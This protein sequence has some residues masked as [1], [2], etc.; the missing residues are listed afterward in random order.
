M[1]CFPFV[2]EKF[3]VGR[4]LKMKNPYQNYRFTFYLP[5][6]SIGLSLAIIR[7]GSQFFQIR[8]SCSY[9]FCG[10]GISCSRRKRDSNPFSTILLHISG[11]QTAPRLSDL[12][13]PKRNTFYLESGFPNS[14]FFFD[15]SKEN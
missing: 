8:I 12:S 14:E 9:S 2:H 1:D 5:L 3:P 15:F 6:I 13:V 4:F 7:N 10:N 11:F